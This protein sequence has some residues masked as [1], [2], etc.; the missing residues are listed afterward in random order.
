MTNIAK[1]KKVSMIQVPNIL[2]DNDKIDCNTTAIYAYLKTKSYN[3]KCT[4]KL[5]TINKALGLSRDTIIRKL[6]ILYDMKLLDYKLNGRNPTII[7][8]TKLDEIQFTQIN[9]KTIDYIINEFELVPQTLRL[10][11]FYDKMYNSDYKYAYPTMIQCSKQCKLSKTTIITINSL[12][13]KHKLIIIKKRKIHEDECDEY[14]SASNQ[15]ILLWKKQLF[16]K[17]NKTN[18]TIIN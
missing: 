9:K 7:N 11:Y 2:I 3:N 14:K 12:L 18:S 8:F 4:I 15:Y 10:C 16:N 17:K 13:T 6:N 1:D 5:N